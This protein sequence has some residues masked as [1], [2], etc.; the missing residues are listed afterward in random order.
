MNRDLSHFIDLES[1]P[2]RS[3]NS[4]Q[5]QALVAAARQA[6]ASDGCYVLPGAIRN[7]ALREMQTEAQS[8]EDCAHYT[9][10]KVNVYFSEEDTSLPENHPRRFMM[11]RSNGFVSG[12]HFPE[13]SSIRDL[14]QSDELKAFIADCLGES[15]IYHYADPIASLTMNVNKPGDRFSWHYDTNEFTVTL[16]IQDCEQGGIFQYVPN[17]RNKDDECYEDVQKLLLGDHSRVKEIKLREGDLQIFKGRYALH[18]ATT[19][20]GSTTRNLV[21]FTYTEKD[22]VIGA[23]YRSMELYGKTLDVHSNARVR[24]DALED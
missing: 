24:A 1:L 7:E 13:D 2:L 11:E 8:I 23:S 20:E 19:A 21:V 18:R 15:H 5:Y 9:R 14:Y 12:D 4:D 6:L 10:N 3:P 17:I 22:N 16:L